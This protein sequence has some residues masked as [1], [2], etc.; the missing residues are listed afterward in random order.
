M[1]L[2]TLVLS[3]FRSI[4]S[5]LTAFAID[6][7]TSRRIVYIDINVSCAIAS[8][9]DTLISILFVYG[10]S[11]E[12]NPSDNTPDPR[13]LSLSSRAA[14]G[15]RTGAALRRRASP[16]RADQRAIL[17]F[18]VAEPSEAT[19]YVGSGHAT[20]D[21]SDYFDGRSQALAT[22]RFA[23]DHDRPIG[24]SRPSDEL[25]GKGAKAAGTRRS[26]L[27][28]DPHR[29]RG[30]SGRRRFT[31]PPEQFT[32]TVLR[33][34]SAKVIQDGRDTWLAKSLLEHRTLAVR[35]SFSSAGP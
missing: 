21:G 17:A 30:T 22:P 5:P 1:L 12:H 23:Q 18:G 25:D 10:R 7:E 15:Q 29:S 28:E 19:G 13:L 8:W 16:H 34:R 32:R 35:V 4:I 6:N 31:S 20:C 14:G 33:A 9:Q 27:E 3:L 2:N 24:R 11:G 26:N